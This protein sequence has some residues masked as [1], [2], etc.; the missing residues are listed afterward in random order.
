MKTAPIQKRQSRCIR[1]S[2]AGIGF[3]RLAA[4][5]FGVVLVSSHF[6]SIFDEYSPLRAALLQSAR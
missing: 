2:M 6:L 5:S 3:S 4:V 1:S